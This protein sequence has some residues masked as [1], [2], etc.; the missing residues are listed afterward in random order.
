MHRADGLLACHHCGHREPV[1]ARCDA[2]GSVSIARHGTGTE[3]LESE[4]EG[5]VFR[6]DAEVAD[7]ARVLAAF[8]QA[9]RGVLVGTQMVAKGHDFPDVDLGVVLDADAT[10]RFP[11]FRA[12]ERTFAL[13]AQLAGRAGRG[14]AGGAVLVQTLAPEAPSIA[15]AARH[16]SDGFLAGEL[17]RREALRYPPF[18]DLVRIVCSSAQ[19]GAA[20][21]AASAVR[22]ELDLDGG[23]VLGPAPLFRLRGRERAQIVVKAGDRAATVRAIGAGVDAVAAD[24]AHKAVA[25]SVDVDPQ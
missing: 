20:F 5:T 11:D 1:P 24:R 17:A 16:D 9:P 18:A 2:C 8:E 23:A 19:P 15:H 3:R 4:L 13:V 14:P 21:A 7:P 25:F 12:E 6:L 22:A 10:L